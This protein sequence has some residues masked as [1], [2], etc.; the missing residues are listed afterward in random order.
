MSLS[1]MPVLARHD[2]ERIHERSLDLLERVGINYNTPRA[3]QILEKADC[4][5]DW[6]RTRVSLPRDL[7][8][9]A[10]QQAPRVVRLCARDPAHDVV[11]DGRRP[12]HT[13]DSQGTQA[14]D[15][16]T[17]ERHDS[18]SEDLR[19][20]L[21][22]ADALDKVEIVNVMVAATDVPAHLRTI[23]HF[24]LAFS[25]TRKHVRTG[26]LHA[27]EVP[28]IVEMAKA[29][30]GSDEFRPVFSV[31]DCTVSPL[32]HEGPM[33]EACIELARLSVPIMI[34][35]MP[36][37]GGTS[38]V[39]L[40]GTILLH[41]TEFLSGLVLFQ[42]VNPGTSIIYGTGASQLDM[43]TGRYGGSADGYGLE[44]ALCDLARFYNLP[45]NLDGLASSSEK[46]DVQYSHEA[47]AAGLLGFLAGADEMYSMGLLGSAQ[48]LSLEKMVLDN[49]MTRQIEI[50][51]RPVLVD[52]EHLQADLIERVGIGGHYL[53]QQE[54]RDYTRR[55]YVP[56]WPPAG[57]TML[58]I[59]HAEALDILRNHQPPP[60]PDGALDRI[61]AIVAE[62][63]RVLAEQ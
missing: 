21:L 34:Y 13:T 5:V 38:P 8:E 39:A 45:V 23:H 19:R 54:T 16:E 25:Q 60:L 27:G 56:V 28:F 14:I 30:A 17:G 62:A 43:R 40:G 50:M 15:L 31:V 20:G 12:H 22:F 57:K 46:L 52:D 1:L 24:A 37:A 61:E 55:E 35:P 42:V 49:H 2:V 44:L 51:T 6:D 33:T 29:A 9:W 36:L 53:N 32:M 26:V 18:T 59:A 11:L 41:N 58:E 3:L 10:L 48:I 4:S 7:V 47:T 63:D